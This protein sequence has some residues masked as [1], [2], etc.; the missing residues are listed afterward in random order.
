MEGRDDRGDEPRLARSVP[1]AGSLI[2]HCHPRESGGRP[3]HAQQKIPAFAGMTVVRG[4]VQGEAFV[5]GLTMSQLKV[6]KMHL[7]C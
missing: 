4:E 1:G 3:P 2:H 5:S 6:E 7:I